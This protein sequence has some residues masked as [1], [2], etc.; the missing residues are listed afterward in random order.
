M[1]LVFGIA[2]MKVSPNHTTYYS[3]T[4]LV[5][6]QYIYIRGIMTADNRYVGLELVK[7][8]AST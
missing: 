2:S 3:D 7:F 1:V 8:V 4:L 5:P 6:S